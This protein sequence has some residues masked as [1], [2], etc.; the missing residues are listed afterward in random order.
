[1]ALQGLDV[2]RALR[3]VEQPLCSLLGHST[4]TAAGSWAGR[5]IDR[6]IDSRPVLA[7]ATSGSRRDPSQSKETKKRERETRVNETELRGESSAER[8]ACL[9]LRPDQT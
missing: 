7:G 9:W 8:C 6:L 2:Y 5:V 1:V 3:D 4:H